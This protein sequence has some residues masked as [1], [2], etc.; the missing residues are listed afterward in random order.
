MS[1]SGSGEGRG[2]CPAKLGTMVVD[3]A[4]AGITWLGHSTALLEVDGVRLLTDPVLRRRV[5]HLRRVKPR[6]VEV[7]DVDAV[8]ISHVHYDHLDLPSLG[9]IGSPGRFVVPRGAGRLLRRRGFDGVVET[10]PGDEVSFGPVVVR[11]TAADHRGW[12]PGVGPRTPALG[13]VVQ[14]S[15]T[16]Y[17]AGDT[18]LFDGMQTLASELHV[19]LL[20]VAGW[21]RRVPEDH[22]DPMR[23]AQALRLLRPRIA[24]PI[25]W[26]TYCRVALA[27]DPLSLSEPAYEFARLAARLA[28]E[29]EVVVLEPGTG[30]TVSPRAASSVRGDAGG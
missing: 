3:P 29:V 18:G 2:R 1:S 13:F 10:A 20:P 7:A 21:G 8:L 23:A 25:H 4:P 5:V 28:P 15:A 11:A 19:A 22:L 27:N 14:G 12:R 30:L 17:F 26:G 16:V 24:V 9:Q 6:P